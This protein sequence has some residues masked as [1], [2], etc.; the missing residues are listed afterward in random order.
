MFVIMVIV[1]MMI[2]TML[3][4]MV[5]VV[6]VIAM[7]VV[8]VPMIMTMAVAM[9]MVLVVMMDALVRTAALRVL[10]EHQR[11][12]GDRYGVGRHAD[13][14]EVDIVE[15]AQ[16]HA[17][18]GEDLALDQEFLAQDRAQRLGDVAVEHDVDRLPALDGVGE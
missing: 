13:A 5:V 11:L 15:V 18:D 3:V 6:M 7:M 17:V 2:V 14:P 16:H 8:M 4:I 1:V 12:D 9:R 10:A